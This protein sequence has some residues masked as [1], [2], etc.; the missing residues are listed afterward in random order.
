MINIIKNVILLLYLSHGKEHLK[1]KKGTDES[2]EVV[3]ESLKRGRKGGSKV[4]QDWSDLQIND[5]IDKKKE[6]GITKK[7]KK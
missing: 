4:Q 5:K 2:N 6:R 1:R 3:D 7:N